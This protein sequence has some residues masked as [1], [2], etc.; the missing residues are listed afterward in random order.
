MSA[1][2]RF[3]TNIIAVAAV[4]SASGCICVTGPTGANGDITFTWTLNGRTCAQSQE[5]TQ[6]V[7]RMPGQTLQNSGVYSC[8]TANTDGIKLLDFRAGTYNYTIEAQNS[9]GTA[10]FAASGKVTVNGDVAE[11]VDLKPTANATGT[12]YFAWTLP[13]G[14]PVD[15]RY[16]AAVDMTIDRATPPITSA[17]SAALYNPNATTLQGVFANL[18]PGQHELI[19]DA[20]DQSGLYFYR[21]IINITVNPA[22]T[23]QHVVSL[24]WLVGTAALRWTF[25]NGVTQ[26]NCAQAGVSVVGVTFRDANGDIT[27][28]VP[29][30]LNTASGLFDG[31]TPYVYGGTY[32]VFLAAFGTAGAV[33][34]SS[35]VAPA[36]VTTQAG[37]FPPLTSSTPQIL[38]TVQ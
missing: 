30:Q 25:S 2:S 35:T 4:M 18:A 16:I 14:T 33:Y 5:I 15:C 29:C 7:V 6:V 22:E 12:A 32:Q 36:T 27:Q 9:A 11:H 20:R 24:D 37:V 10:V 1:H 28:E 3:L 21:K 13:A 19:F 8:T 26:L 17:C 34:R 23:T 31:Y 38:M